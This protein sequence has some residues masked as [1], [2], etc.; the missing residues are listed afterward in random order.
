MMNESYPDDLYDDGDYWVE[1][2]MSEIRHDKIAHIIMGMG[3]G[4][5]LTVALATSIAW[6]IS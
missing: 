4:V 3:I 6:F 1:K 2:R 5:L